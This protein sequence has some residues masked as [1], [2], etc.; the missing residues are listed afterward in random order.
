MKMHDFSSGVSDYVIAQATVTVFFPI[1]KR[2]NA[3]ICCMRCPYL[4]SNERM[5]QLNKEPVAYPHNHVGDRC[6]LVEVE[7]KGD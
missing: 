6:P 1:D 3:D 7:K 2:G 5:C 4:S